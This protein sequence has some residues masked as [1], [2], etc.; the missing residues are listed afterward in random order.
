[1]GPTG[2]GSAA[3]ARCVPGLR[4]RTVRRA[5]VFK[6][7]LQPR[8]NRSRWTGGI[9]NDGSLPTQLGP[10][11]SIALGGIVS[12]SATRAGAGMNAGRRASPAELLRTGK[13]GRASI[14]QI[15]PTGMRLEDGDQLLGFVLDVIP[16]DGGSTFRAMMARRVPDSA[17]GRAVPG[18]SLPV[19][20][21][22]ADPMRK[23]AIDWSA[24]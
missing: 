19:S 4:P 8:I 6:L 5:G 21:D 23:V 2:F 7:R 11:I 24:S 14:V 20:Y 13:L 12:G 1:M 22:P 17:I 9:T 18:L 16:G 10:L 3:P 15:F